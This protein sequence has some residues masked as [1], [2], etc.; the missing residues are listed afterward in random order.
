MKALHRWCK[1]QARRILQDSTALDSLRSFYRG[2]GTVLLYH[3]V[4]SDDTPSDALHPYSGLTVQETLFDQHMAYLKERYECISLPHFV[5]RLRGG[6][7]HRDCVAVTFDD[8]YRDN[9]T[10]AL[11]IL[12]RYQVPATVFVTTG[13]VDRMCRAWWYE[14]EA[15][16]GNLRTLNVTW[17]DVRIARVLEKVEER[18]GAMRDI[19]TLLKR[20]PPSGQ[21]AVLQMLS[22]GDDSSYSYDQDVLSWDEVHSLDRHELITIGA[23]TVNHYVLSTL[24]EGLLRSELTRGRTIL[25]ERLSHPVEHFAYPYGGAFEAGAREFEAARDAGFASAWTT[26]FGHVQESHRDTLFALPR[27]SIDHYDTVERFESK[28]SGV[29]SM[30]FNRGRRRK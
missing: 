17:G 25:E 5:E 18:Y 24:S 29:D 21:Q 1:Q 10:R 23:H 12:E 26:R 7:L 11:P 22:G 15:L 27:I 6:T 20:L 30:I 28:L 9:Y 8:G 19:D 4:V 16:I 14:Q 13:L 3:R 2:I